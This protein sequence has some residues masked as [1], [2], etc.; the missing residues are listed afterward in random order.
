ML[1]ADVKRVVVLDEQE[2]PVGIITDGDL[3]A[4]VSPVLR[5]NVLQALAARVLRS[6]LSRGE[7]SAREV[8]S[9]S[10]LSAPQETTI[11]EAITLMLREGRKRLVVVDEQG[12]PIGIVDRQTLLA[13]SIGG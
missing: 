13:A 5:R 11:V 2:R 12:R 3:V 8:M 7:A 1:Q 6:D 10:V 4:R 9:E